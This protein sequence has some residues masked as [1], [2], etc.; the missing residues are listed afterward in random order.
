MNIS[1][2]IQKLRDSANMSQESFAAL[3]GVSRQSV[4]KWESGASVPELDKIIKIAKYFGVTVDSVLFGGSNRITPQP[5]SKEIKPNYDNIE[6][7]DP[8]CNDL[9][10]EFAEALDEGLDVEKYKDVFTAVSAMPKSEY[11]KEMSGILSNIVL[12]ANQKAGYK[13]IEPSSLDEIKAL[14]K[15]Y[16]FKAEMPDKN[17]LKAKIHGAWAGRACGC[18]LGKPIEGIRTDELFP[19]LKSTGNYPMHRYILS[20]DITD[21]MCDSYDFCLSGKCY[22]D[23]V[24]GMPVDDDTNYVV[25]AQRVIDESGRDFTSKD[26]SSA[27][28]KYQSVNSYFTA[29]RVAYC[30]ILNGFEPPESAVHKN[31]YREWIGAQIRG[32]YF[33]YIN[34]GNPEAAADMCFT[35]AAVSHTKNGIYGE[36]FAGAMIAC[37]AV[38]DNIED[39]IKGGLAQIPSTSRLY[40]AITGIIGD[41]KNGV[42]YDGCIKKIHTL[43]DEHTGHGWCH[44]IPNAMIVAA[45]LLYGNKDFGKS[46]CLAVSAG[47]DTDCNGAT[48]GS[49]VGMINTIGGIPTEWTAP[50]NDKIHTSIFGYE[51]VSISQCAEH[52]LEHIK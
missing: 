37:A 39:I 5:Q 6:S 29:E 46:L 11:K 27:W 16:T 25:L 42:S 44:T 45:A 15:D 47:F 21:E 41:F 40:E 9:M 51:T 20:S 4:Q 24:D 34:P 12:N 32:D 19:L 36:M 1:T 43:F 50:L 22:A 49:I 31:P 48:V 52:T 26:I 38:T 10:V 3:F 2:S 13:Y 28:I 30:N 7:W 17:L 14:R 33:G 18:L 8:L 35:D 23:T